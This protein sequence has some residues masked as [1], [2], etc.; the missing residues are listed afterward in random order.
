M[1]APAETMTETASDMPAIPKTSGAIA[2]TGY[3]GAF[4]NAQTFEAAQRMAMALVASSMVPKQYQGRENLGNAIIALEMSQRIGANPLMV[5]QNLYLVHGQPGWSA[6]FMIATFNQCGRF[7][8]IRYEWKGQ[9]GSQ[10]YGCRAYA[11]EK[12]TGNIIHGP[13]IT[14]GLVR[15]EG[16]NNKNGS[17]W[18]TMAEKMFMY[19]AA[20]WMIDLYAPEIS[21]GLPTSEQLEDIIDVDPTTGEVMGVEKTGEQGSRTASVA[22]RVVAAAAEVETDEQSDAGKSEAQEAGP[23]PLA[24]LQQVKAATAPEQLDDLEDMAASLDGRNSDVK[25]LRQAIA[26]KREA[27]AATE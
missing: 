8:A 20:A 12:S 2:A 19:R 25:A 17:K 10:D 23:D 16:W 24:L 7:S 9:E 4:A 26:N 21:M 11:T 18:T 6:K 5:M 22:S 14:W 3:Q 13:W 15:A 1:S 27:M